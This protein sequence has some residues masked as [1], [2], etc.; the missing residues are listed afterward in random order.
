MVRALAIVAPLACLTVARPGAA[1]VEDRKAEVTFKLVDP[2]RLRDD[3]QIQGGRGM[4]GVD[5][6]VVP[7]D[8]GKGQR[9][10]G[11][12]RA[13]EMMRMRHD[14]V[15]EVTVWPGGG[16]KDVYLKDTW[17]AGAVG[18]PV[19]IRVGDR[20]KPDLTIKAGEGGTYAFD[21]PM[22]LPKGPYIVRM[23]LYFSLYNGVDDAPHWSKGNKLIKWLTRVDVE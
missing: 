1:Q 8:D 13:N 23:F 20:A 17:P 12:F 22:G 16:D 10:R 2:V 6:E 15:M 21:M 14:F 5:M 3:G 18:D 19:Y 4:G 11:H 9:L 7:R